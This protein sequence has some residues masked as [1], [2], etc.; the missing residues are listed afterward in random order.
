MI[1]SVGLQIAFYYGLTGI[2]CV[3]FYRRTL[4]KS[5]RFFVM[6]GLIPLVGGIFLFIMFVYALIQYAA[7]DWAV[8]GNGNNITIWGIGATAVVG[9]VALLLGFVLI[10][11]Q[12]WRSPDFFRG[13]TLPRRSAD[14]VLLG[15]EDEALPSTLPGSGEQATVIAPDLSNLPAGQVAV[16]P[17][18][19]KVYRA[20]R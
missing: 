10:A 8:D 13:R 15:T 14:L 7:P 5:G 1:D 20:P 11:F 17:E 9:I 19:G 6:R 16:D 4:L 3:W 12:W 18:T 2:A